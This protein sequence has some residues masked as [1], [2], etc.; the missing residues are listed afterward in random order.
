MLKTIY[1]T[2][3]IP[4]GNMTKLFNILSYYILILLGLINEILPN[5]KIYKIKVLQITSL[6]RF[7]GVQQ[8]LNDPEIASQI[9]NAMHHAHETV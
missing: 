4:K 3:I 9:V 2:M 1:N 6:H 5:G 8:L 7:L